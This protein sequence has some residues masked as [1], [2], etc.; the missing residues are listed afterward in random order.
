MSA[1]TF[2]EARS[3]EVIL[4]SGSQIGTLLLRTAENEQRANTNRELRWCLRATT[5]RWQEPHQRDAPGGSAPVAASSLSSR[6]RSVLER[7]SQGKSNKE[8]AKD[9]CIA[10]ETVKSHVKNIF[11]KLDV[12]KRAQAVAC[13]Q[14]SGS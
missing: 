4:D 11:V 10:P 5:S 13:A 7:I 2:E 9:L 3:E 1:N 8:I 14:A 12:K 6:E